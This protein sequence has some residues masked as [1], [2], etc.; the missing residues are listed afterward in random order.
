MSNPDRDQGARNTWRRIDKGTVVASV[1]AFASAALLW[2]YWGVTL[3]AEAEPA[4]G[5]TWALNYRGRVVYLLD[6]QFALL[7]ALFA[8]FVVGLI[9]LILIEALVDPFERRRGS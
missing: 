7:M 8:V 5:R 3:P 6:G 2:M 1:L 4:I 9:A